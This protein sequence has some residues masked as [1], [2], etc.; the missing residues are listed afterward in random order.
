MMGVSELYQ[1]FTLCG[2]KLTTDSRNIE[3]GGLFVALK[4]ENFD[5]NQFASKALE[6]GAA[7][8]LIDDPAVMKETDGRYLL[9]ENGLRSLQELS[10]HH[11][12]VI[13]PKLIAIGGSNGKTTTRELLTAV[14]S[15]KYPVH[16]SPSN[17][18]NHIGVPLSLLGMPLNT[19]YAVIEMGTN[20][21]G[22]MAEL[23]AIAEPD[24]GLVTN[25]GKEHLEGFGSLE[26]VARE[27]SELYYHLLKHNGLA[28]VNADDEW[29][30]RM[31]SRLSK[32]VYYGS[33]C[34]MGSMKSSLFISKS[35]PSLSLQ[36]GNEEF[37]THLFGR[38]NFSNILAAIAVGSYFGVEDQLAIEAIQN[39]QPSNQRS[40]IIEWNG[41]MLIADCYNAN[42]SSMEKALESMQGIHDR[43]KI[44][45]LG[46]MFELG[47]HA[48]QEHR[49]ILE[50]AQQ[51][52][53]DA[54][55]V[56]G[57]LFNEAANTSDVK[58]YKSQELLLKDLSS[59]LMKHGACVILFK[60]SR[61]MKLDRLIS[62]LTD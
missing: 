12:R 23:L 24:F 30:V 15:Q 38:Y 28:F 57:E 3:K 21:P 10:R 54:L 17:W 33:E 1:Y 48:L 60:A 32:V 52:Q 42:P 45:V 22:E 36:W 6:Q 4:G 39:F 25:I 61:G 16:A 20:H 40:Q 46:D 11:R 50:K 7:Y 9:C 58:V 43:P 14:L 37:E 35:F 53:L 29:L 41:H 59:Y 13:A 34:A 55:F 51:A 5:G 47:V 62:Q 19:E 44:A 2:Y 56:I 31:A 27:E 49:T 8:V 26:A 18:N